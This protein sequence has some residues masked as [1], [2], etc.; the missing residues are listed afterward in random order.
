MTDSR[1]SKLTVEVIRAAVAK[2]KA[3][4][5]LLRPIRLAGTD[6]Y[7]WHPTLGWI[8]PDKVKLS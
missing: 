3:D 7:V 8:D 5:C 6:Y 2:A 4:G 1:Q